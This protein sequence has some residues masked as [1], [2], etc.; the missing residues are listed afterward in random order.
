MVWLNAL[1]DEYVAHNGPVD[2]KQLLRPQTEN[3]RPR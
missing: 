1:F 2:S 3:K